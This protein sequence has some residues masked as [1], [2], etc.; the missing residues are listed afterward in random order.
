MY[1][2]KDL[3]H[4]GVRENDEKMDAKHQCAFER[5]YVVGGLRADDVCD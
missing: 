2:Y 5:V 3:K 4:K 1:E